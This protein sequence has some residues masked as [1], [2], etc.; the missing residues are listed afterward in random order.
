M[1]DKLLL[2][3]LESS[4]VLR[5]S[6]TQCAVKPN[7]RERM[8]TCT[9][10]ESRSPQYKESTAITITHTYACWKASS[11]ASSSALLSESVWSLS[12]PISSSSYAR[13]Q[14]KDINSEPG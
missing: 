7:G 5:H 6:G 12:M 2:P 10:E 11:F 3:P 13:V 9:S 1:V 14:Q 8:F 4:E